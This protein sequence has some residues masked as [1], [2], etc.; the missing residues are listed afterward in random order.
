MSIKKCGLLCI[1]LLGI[2]QFIDAAAPRQRVRLAPGTSTSG[3][4][5]AGGRADAAR[6]VV[7]PRKTAAE[8][9]EEG[10]RAFNARLKA[11]KRVGDSPRGEA[12]GIAR[13]ESVVK[14][15]DN[16]WNSLM[17]VALSVQDIKSLDLY[18]NNLKDA[19]NLNIDEAVAMKFSEG[20]SDE[21]RGRLERIEDRLA[22][23]RIALDT[24][25]EEAKRKLAAFGQGPAAAKPLVSAKPVKTFA[26]LQRMADIY[27][28]NWQEYLSDLRS[29]STQFELDSQV[30]GLME[31]IKQN[32][33]VAKALNS[34][35][36]ASLI[37]KFESYRDSLNAEY[38]RLARE[39]KRAGQQLLELAAPQGRSVSGVVGQE[40][41]GEWHPDKETK[42]TLINY[43]SNLLPARLRF[44]QSFT[45]T[46]DELKEEY[47]RAIDVA[48]Q[49]CQ[50]VGKLSVPDRRLSNA[51]ETQMGMLKAAYN[52]GLAQLQQKAPV[53]RGEK[54]E[55]QEERKEGAEAI[56]TQ[57]PMTIQ[58]WI[59]QQKQMHGDFLTAEEET[60]A[61]NF[62]FA[63]AR[64]LHRDIISPQTLSS[65]RTAQ[66]LT[67]IADEFFKQVNQ[68]VSQV[69]GSVSGKETEFLQAMRNNH[70]TPAIV[71]YFFDYLRYLVSSTADLLAKRAREIGATQQGMQIYQESINIVSLIIKSQR[72]FNQ[73]LRRNNIPGWGSSYTA[74]EYKYR[75]AHTPR[76]AEVERGR[77]VSRYVQPAQSPAPRQGGQRVLDDDVQAHISYANSQLADAI[78]R[79]QNKLDNALLNGASQDELRKLKEDLINEGPLKNLASYKNSVDNQLSQAQK[80]T[81]AAVF[82]SPTVTKIRAMEPRSSVRGSRQ[83]GFSQRGGSV[84]G[85]APKPSVGAFGGESSGRRAAQPQLLK[86]EKQV[87]F[88]VPAGGESAQNVESAIAQK[89]KGF[90]AILPNFQQALNELYTSLE[91][92]GA[93]KTIQTTQ[94]HDFMQTFLSDHFTAWKNR[95]IAQLQ[96]EEKRD[97]AAKVEKFYNEIEAKVYALKPQQLQSGAGRRSASVEPV[98]GGENFDAK[99][100]RLKQAVE[101]ELVATKL[102]LQKDL[103]QAKLSEKTDNELF[104]IRQRAIENSKKLQELKQWGSFLYNKKDLS[105]K[106][107]GNK[108]LDFYESIWNKIEAM[109]AQEVLGRSVQSAGAGNSGW[110]AGIVES[111][112]RS[113]ASAGERGASVRREA[114]RAPEQR[115]RMDK[116]AKEAEKI[117]SAEENQRA[118][119]PKLM[120]EYARHLDAQLDSLNA[121]KTINQNEMQFNGRKEE[122]E[123]FWGDRLEAF[124]QA[125]VSEE[126]R[127]ILREYIAKLSAAKYN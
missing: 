37:Y 22:E 43:A 54:R 67:Q 100:A 55:L 96:K 81:I 120:Q 58:S 35:E 27:A 78:P 68:T 6:A 20:V 118:T 116:P 45:G 124:I 5:A 23:R 12:Q 29:A 63:V 38:K 14:E 91:H 8:L 80:S 103:N 126:T 11:M 31:G 94:I 36:G 119:I 19:I 16:N 113:A 93:D 46:P 97:E 32:I 4:S 62:V 127:N 122:Y 117:K 109:R 1:C 85:F 88:A 112:S 49:F 50:E 99:F 26:G 17:A 24:V 74:G 66:G 57:Q 59:M 72:E 70:F 39:I 121:S 79:L 41:A 83:Q 61:R 48:H 52:D 9:E 40:P 60:Y 102:E 7:K 15:Y 18:V 123:K 104:V 25:Y 89:R 71:H 65:I 75:G 107:Q 44:F 86:Q 69:S 92:G 30:A 108:V 10:K 110:A 106:E 34:K 76:A 98:V 2:N 125:G 73:T 21:N 111:M 33:E 77:G 84:S 13:L 115:A 87:R 105:V 56:A 51:C 47:H 53:G 28:D 95:F 64:D 114:L 42:M 90:N 3:F 82:N 101:S